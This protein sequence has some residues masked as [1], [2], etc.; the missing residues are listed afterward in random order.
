[1]L[2]YASPAS[3]SNLPAWSHY[4]YFRAEHLHRF[5]V[6][7]AKRISNTSIIR[8]NTIRGHSSEEGVAD[9]ACTNRY[10]A[11]HV[12]GD[13]RAC[14]PEIPSGSGGADSRPGRP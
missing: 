8:Q 12:L 11:H 3:A 14:P 13:A 1:M 9:S 2:P 10:S 6:G 4:K 7:S 5:G